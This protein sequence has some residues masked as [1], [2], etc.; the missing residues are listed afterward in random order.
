MFRI[1]FKDSSSVAE[2]AGGYNIFD[3]DELPKIADQ[4]GFC[5]DELLQ[6][7]E[8][9]MYHEYGEIIGGVITVAEA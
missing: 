4:F 2:T 9:D 1:W 8:V 6:K 5:A 7:G 3:K